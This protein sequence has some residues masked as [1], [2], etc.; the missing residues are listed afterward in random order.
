MRTGMK[1]SVILALM[2]TCC[3]LQVSAADVVKTFEETKISEAFEIM[4]TEYTAFAKMF[5][6]CTKQD[7]LPECGKPY[8]DAR[9][10]YGRA[11]HNYEVLKMANT[12]AF[13]ELDAPS[14]SYSSLAKNL[15]I[16]GFIEIIEPENVSFETLVVGVNKW[17][18]N[19]GQPQTSNITMF[20]MQAIGIEASTL[21][22]KG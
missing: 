8:D 10:K 2:A 18:E 14:I 9:S 1:K 7:D 15:E 13:S 17:Q 16:M 3:H 20:T 5:N 4:S 6:V 19:Q 22:N 12:D 11:K 21:L